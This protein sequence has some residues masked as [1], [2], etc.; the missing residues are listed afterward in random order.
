VPAPQLDAVTAERLADL[1]LAC[2]H[3]EY[4]NKL[5]HHILLSDQD[6][7]PPRE[8]TPAFYGCYDWHSAVHGHWMLARLSRVFPD[9]PLA[10]RARQALARSL[11]VENL[12]H[13]AEYMQS[14]ARTSFE[15]PYGL[16]WLLQL[17]AEFAEW[18][19]SEAAKW[20]AA[21]RNLENI[22]V[23]R[24]E[25]WLPKLSHPVRSG[26]HSQS[27]FSLGLMLDYARTCG[28]RAFEEMLESKIR[29]FYL[30][31]RD[32]PLAY[33]PSGE[34]FLS[35]CLAQADVVRRILDSRRFSEWLYGFAPGIPSDG[36][37]W[38]EPARVVDP[39]DPKLAHLDGLNLSRAWMLRGILSALAAGDPRTTSLERTAAGHARAGLASITG[40]HYEGAHWIATFAVYLLTDRGMRRRLPA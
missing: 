14:D 2:I 18:D 20:A 23:A 27:A 15:R 39:S 4:P 21:L 6:A 28:R 16:A 9:A 36:R 33:E 8:L 32:C 10:A 38:I 37:S 7:K 24:V 26:E 19:D 17:A 3:R 12:R 13:E 30:N 35:P 31:D 5:G 11:T 1:A 34:D 22:V 29:Q 25:A 40:E